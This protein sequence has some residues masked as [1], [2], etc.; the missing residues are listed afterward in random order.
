MVRQTSSRDLRQDSSRTAFR[1]PSASAAVNVLTEDVK[2]TRRTVPAR[3]QERSTLMVPLVAG[4]STRDLT[5]S[6]ETGNITGG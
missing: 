6:S 5:C 4:S 1:R 3:T 2:T